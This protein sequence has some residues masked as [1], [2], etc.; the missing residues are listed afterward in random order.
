MAATKIYSEYD[1]FA[2]FYN[3][4]WGE[5]F[6]R[7]A[8]AIFNLVLF[9]HL[10]RGSRVLDLC[11]GTGHLA[12]ALCAQGYRVTGLDGSKAMLEF[13]RR[14]AREAAFIRA[15]ARAF[16]LP[17]RFQAVIAA[18]DSL[19]HLMNLAELTQV[20]RNVYAALLP[21]GIFLFDLNME[22][23][24]E[25]FGQTLEMIEDDHV[26]VVRGNYDS[27]TKLKRYDLTMFRLLAG[28]WQRTD[29]SLW[30]HYYSEAE[31]MA[32]LADAGFKQVKTYDA[33]REFGMTLS[34]GRMFYL[35]RKD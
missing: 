14:N 10:P 31:V 7:P 33:Q 12:A 21:G 29:L 27:E 11:C 8:L 3:R 26:C 1:N 17:E 24:A 30:Q 32:A 25:Q 18:F 35:A 23:E 9:P 22:D 19:N 16:N 6:C 34:D 20:F 2:W 4:Y 15:D 28:N 5:E 13:A